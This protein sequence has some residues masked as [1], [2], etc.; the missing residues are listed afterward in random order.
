MQSRFHRLVWEREPIHHLQM[1]VPQRIR[2]LVSPKVIRP[3]GC[4][5]RERTT[6][7]ER[8]QTLVRQMLGCASALK[9]E[10]DANAF[11][12]APHVRCCASPPALRLSNTHSCWV[13]I[14]T[15]FVSGRSVFAIILRLTT[16][17]RGRTVDWESYCRRC[18]W[19]AS[20][21]RRAQEL[22]RLWSRLCAYRAYLGTTP[23]LPWMWR[24]RP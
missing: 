23:M 16:A 24:R 18:C 19:T 12:R 6:S 11:A 7:F 9:E 1:C 21:L 10:Q 4:C 22:I 2:Y 3:A 5:M 15:C 13:S 14:A 20:V 8:V 17:C